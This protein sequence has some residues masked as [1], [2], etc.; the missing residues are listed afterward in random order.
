MTVLRA[1]P[2]ADEVVAIDGARRIP[3]DDWNRLGRRGFH[4]HAW[5]TVAERCGWQ[6]RHVAVSGAEG[7][8][9][10]V[11]A[12]LVAGGVAHDLHDRWLG[13]LRGAAA[14][15]GLGLRPVLSVQAPFA[16]CSEPMTGG[17][18]LRDD[19][20]DRVLAAL[21]MAG[22]RAGARAIVW[23]FVDA[24]REDLI[25]AARERG[26]AVVYAGAAAWLPVRWG[27]FEDYLDSR[28]KN[29]RR[30]VRADLRALA[31]ACVRTEVVRD[32]GDAAA[33]MDRLYRDAFLRRNGRPAPTPD[34]LFA[35]LAAAGPPAPEREAQLAWQGERL[36]GMSLNLRG[37][38]VLDGGLAA[39][40]ADHAGGPVYYHDLCYQ[41]LR[42]AMAHGVG[43]IELGASALYAKV[44]RGATLRR[45]VALVRGRSRVIHQALAGLGTVVARRVEAK[46]R[47]SL[48][49]LWRPAMDAGEER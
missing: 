22:E 44:L 18:A 34:D 11:P 32:F 37:A 49:A 16:Q 10:I 42:R 48:G 1:P 9:A 39:F 33:E 14:H 2:Q 41:P 36:V 4:L 26:Y 20:I 19:T 21:E 23:P 45:R 28:S 35:R 3:A 47:R 6:G 5:C 13:P 43:A 27:S 7:L 8:R 46:E 17:E 24:A 25:A 30:T 38:D 29:V 15:A 40:T 31:A 12:Y